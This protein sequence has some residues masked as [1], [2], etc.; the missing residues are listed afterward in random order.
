M[1]GYI[2]KYT[3]PDGKVYIGQTVRPVAARHREHITPSTGR[4]NVGFWEAYQ[5]YGAEIPDVLE[6][7]ETNDAFELTNK[8]NYL[9]LFYIEK[10][11]A[12]DPAYGYNRIPGG[13]GGGP[14]QRKINKVFNKI[15]QEVWGDREQF[16]SDVL[17]VL[18][19]AFED[20]VHLDE[21]QM[22]FLRDE[23]LSSM[24]YFGKEII[25][26]TDS[27]CLK[28][29][30]DKEDEYE[31]VLAEEAFS[32]ARFLI[33]DIHDLESQEVARDVLLYM[34]AHSEEI[35]EEGTILQIAKD[36]TVVKEFGSIT[37]I[38]HDLNLSYNTN[39][40]NVLE[41][42]QKTAY[43]FIWRWKNNQNAK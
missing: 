6:V 21:S 32:F 26:L 22:S 14:F 18:E 11:H 4:V 36:G 2:Y 17:E 42:K 33:I 9:E 24:I 19:Q 16:Y 29:D 39:I 31:S 20:E 15:F 38:M 43:G 41:G 34:N 40:Y 37:E 10:F 28:F 5:K 8:L 13:L 3:F 1:K 12:L 27:G 35:I 25:I 23:I 30:Y 7:V